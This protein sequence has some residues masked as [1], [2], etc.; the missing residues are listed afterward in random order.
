MRSLPHLGLEVAPVGQLTKEH[1]TLAP[2]GSLPRVG[3]GEALPESAG[4]WVLSSPTIEMLSTP[5]FH[6]NLQR[7]KGERPL[8]VWV[9]DVEVGEVLC[10]LPWVDALVVEYSPFV[11]VADEE[12]FWR[13]KSQGCAIWVRNPDG[14]S[15]P[16]AVRGPREAL[17]ESMLTEFP[18]YAGRSSWLSVAFALAHPA[19]TSLLVEG[20]LSEW[21][22]AAGLPPLDEEQT[23]S[24]KR[25][26][27]GL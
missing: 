12:L 6:S 4:G 27:S 23:R 22:Q 7:Q 13:A 26:A 10:G 15:A 18:D 24:L 11:P 1:V 14:L 8:A 9:D 19:V 17:W 21:Q 5:S 3:A 16:P 2:L 20:D 25:L